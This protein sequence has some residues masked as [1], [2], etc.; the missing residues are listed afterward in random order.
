MTFTHGCLRRPPT[1]I[2]PGLLLL[3]A[4][5]AEAARPLAT[6]DAGVQAVGQCELDGYAGRARARTIP[7]STALALQFG[8]GAVRSTYLGVAWA[9]EPGHADRLQTLVLAGK[10]ALREA[11]DEEAGYAL[12]WG[13]VGRKIRGTNFRYDGWYAL[14]SRTAS[15]PG[16]WT[17]D[18]NLGASHARD[19]HVL[20]ARWAL[21]AEHVLFASVRCGVEA[22]ADNHDRTPWL[23][24]GASAD[25]PLKG[26]SVNASWGAQPG[27]ARNRL[28]TAGVTLDF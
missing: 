25:L 26:G 24:A 17:I 11:T 12:A 10:T 22:F 3:A 2:L 14:L 28:A 5:A 7:D 8:C 4:G 6:D 16:G 27:A 20:T 9:G 21:A 15:M 18:A 13:T 19:S 1:A 23:Q